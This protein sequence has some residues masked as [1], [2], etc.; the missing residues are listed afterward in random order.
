MD[1]LLFGSLLWLSFVRF[2][3][4]MVV[5]P[6][7]IRRPTLPNPSTP[8]E[9]VI[10]LHGRLEADD[11]ESSMSIPEPSD[12]YADFLSSLSEKLP[13]NYHILM[14][15][16]HK[17]Y[18]DWRREPR[19]LTLG[20]VSSAIGQVIHNHIEEMQLLSENEPIKVTMISF[21]MGAA[22]LLK[23]LANDPILL[24]TKSCVDIQ[25]LILIEPVW[26]CWLPFAVSEATSLLGDSS[27]GAT[28]ISDVQT[29]AIAGTNDDEVK[30]DSGTTEHGLRA[31]VT[32][33]IS[34]EYPCCRN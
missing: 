16:Y 8:D 25:R 15:A 29:L 4:G 2:C 23:L 22:F 3:F 12:L 28:S 6:I 33:A 10:F 7:V 27:K 31:T 17:H 24:R 11:H 13:V 30:C 19:D 1:I 21:S 5:H 26:R 34:A 20:P 14:P 9:L 32:E 18:K